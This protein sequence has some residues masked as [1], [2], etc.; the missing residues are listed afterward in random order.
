MSHESSYPVTITREPAAPES[1]NP[2][3]EYWVART[4]DGDWYTYCP[5]SYAATA[6]SA[7]AQIIHPAEFGGV[8]SS[9]VTVDILTGEDGPE[10]TRDIVECAICGTTI[11]DYEAAIDADW[12][13]PDTVCEMNHDDPI[14]P[15]CCTQYLTTDADSGELIRRF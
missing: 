3:G 6:E 10:P 9:V 13:A 8:R 12:L 11:A 7:V 1:G 4:Y 15:N 14:C 5:A 2:P